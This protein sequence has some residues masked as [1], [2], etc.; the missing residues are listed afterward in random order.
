[1][2][3]RSGNSRDLERTSIDM[4]EDFGPTFI[5]QAKTDSDKTSVSDARMDSWSGGFVKSDG[6][7]VRLF[8]RPALRT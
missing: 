7:R 2:G 6:T 3:K 8:I 4:D 5:A 1:M